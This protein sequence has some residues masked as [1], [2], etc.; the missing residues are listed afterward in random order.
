MPK[1]RNTS[2]SSYLALVLVNIG[3]PFVG[4]EECA[5]VAILKSVIGGSTAKPRRRLRDDGA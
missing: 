4:S 2:L 1:R 5:A 3:S